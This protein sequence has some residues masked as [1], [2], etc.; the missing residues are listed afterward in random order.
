MNE[1][2]QK[3][4][5]MEQQLIRGRESLRVK[6]PDIKKTLEVVRILKDKHAKEE[7]EE[8]VL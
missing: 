3:Y 5:F 8:K 1:I 4:K 6:S 7:E 2:Y